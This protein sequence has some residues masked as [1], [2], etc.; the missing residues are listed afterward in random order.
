MTRLNGM[1]HTIFFV[2]DTSGLMVFDND[3]VGLCMGDH[4]EIRTVLHRVQVSR[5]SR[6]ALA[7]F[8]TMKVGNLI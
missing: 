8:F 7:L 5:S 6:A 3:A 1:L 2:D 4:G